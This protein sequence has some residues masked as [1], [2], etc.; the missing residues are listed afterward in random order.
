[1]RAGS[2]HSLRPRFP[3]ELTQIYPSD[4]ERLGTRQLKAQHPLVQGLARGAGAH[5]PNLNTVEPRAKGLGK[6]VC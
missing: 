3:S 6:F 1:M 5:L 4:R 2:D